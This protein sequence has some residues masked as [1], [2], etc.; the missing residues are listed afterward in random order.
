MNA[1]EKKSS[2]VKFKY[3][4][5]GHSMMQRGKVTLAN[6]QQPRHG[7][8]K[9]KVKHACNQNQV[10]LRPKLFYKAKGNTFYIHIK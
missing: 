2:E 9:T 6:K 7:M 10:T 4:I 3:F 1:R 8:E 5:G